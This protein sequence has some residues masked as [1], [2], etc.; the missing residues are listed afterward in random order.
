MAT[1]GPSM[2]YGNTRGAHHNG[3]VS[4]SIGYQWAKGFN[5]GGL[6][7]H[8]RDHGKEV[9]AHS[10]G[11]YASK[12]VHFANEVDRRNFKSVIDGRGTTYKYDP[13]D[14]R[15]VEVTKDGYVISY[16]HTGKKF[17]Y[18]NKKG[19]VITVWIKH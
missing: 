19:E 5:R 1:K 4:E 11:E 9:G 18:V 2:R 8:F 7:R 12:G 6:A 13:R 15:L 3:K 14:G 16:R 10:E 17:T